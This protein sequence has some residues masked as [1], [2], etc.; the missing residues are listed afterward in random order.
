MFATRNKCLTSS[1]KKLL[2]TKESRGLLI[3]CFYFLSP[4][5]NTATT[6]KA[7]VTRSDALVPRRCT[8]FF[9]DMVG[10]FL[11]KM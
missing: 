2:E 7:L 6:S 10:R 3:T 11:T 4:I 1:N 5:A 8:C 9:Q